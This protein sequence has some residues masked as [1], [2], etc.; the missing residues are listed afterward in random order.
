MTVAQILATRRLVVCVG[1]GGVGKTTLAAA[2]GVSAANHGRHVLV[3]TIDPAR[4]LADA[5]GVEGLGDS[6]TEVPV[7]G[8]SGSMHAAM[9]EAGPSYDRLLTGLTDDASV[10]EQ[11]RAN[12]IY[13][14]F[15]RTLARSHAYV[16]VERLHDAMH[17]SRWDL[18]VLDTPP[19]TNAVDILDA[20][21]RL[22]GFLEHSV[23]RWLLPDGNHASGRR[24][25]RGG[26]AIRVALRALMGP[27]L[28]GEASAFFG[29]FGRLRDV[30]AS[31]AVRVERMLRGP[32][33]AFVL[34]GNPSPG[35]LATSIHLDADLRARGI[36]IEAAIM[37]RS[38]E[39]LDRDHS[40]RVVTS[41][42]PEL[43]ADLPDAYRT[44]AE[45]LRQ[46]R[47]LAADRNADARAAASELMVLLP[48][49]TLRLAIPQLDGAGHSVEDLGRFGPFF[50]GSVL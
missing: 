5:L 27:R 15:S 16:A 23:V 43:P 24:F 9:V 14:V 36:S 21:G 10:L 11:L 30:F 31:R 33:T 28:L 25:A 42:A 34:V 49:S 32:E 22:T 2:M 26:R 1:A 29:L 3:L 18:I 50:D 45:R 20:P 6:A 19:A 46:F 38:Y 40:T 17:D 39:I 41:V 37:N 48:V 44:P 13:R 47:S 35:T 7:Q 8:A 12:P 4:R